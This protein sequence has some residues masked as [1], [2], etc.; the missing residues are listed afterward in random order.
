MGVVGALAVALLA[1]V[2]QFTVSF[3]V[4]GRAASFGS[5]SFEFA[6]IPDLS[7]TY[8]V[9]T[10][11]NSGVGLVTARELAKKGAH[12]I[13]T[14]RDETKGQEALL[15]MQSESSEPWRGRVE[16]LPLD[17]S[18]MQS[19]KDF[20]SVITSRQVSINALILNAGVMMVPYGET[21]E[22]LEWQFGVNHIGHFLL[23]KLLLGTM[24]ARA[25]IVHVSSIGHYFTYYPEGIRFDLLNNSAEYNPM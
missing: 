5:P 7:G 4:G 22:G 18:S 17:L 24:R 11:A 10:G 19:V 3:F 6:D 16:F 1:V 12:V 15:Q 20:A 14:C 2:C 21:K 23:V 9:V 13:A 25:R 8:A